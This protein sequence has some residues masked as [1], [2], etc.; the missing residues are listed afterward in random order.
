M[1]QLLSAEREESYED[2]AD[3]VIDVESGTV[4]E[5]SNKIL[6]LNILRGDQ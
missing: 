3:F 5:I 2:V 4:E 1:L 6:A